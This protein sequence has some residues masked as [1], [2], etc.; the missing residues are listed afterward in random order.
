MNIIRIMALITLACCTSLHAANDSRF[1]RFALVIG[2][3]DGGAS[4]TQLRFSFSDAGSF[5]RVM[6]EIGG[7]GKDDAMLLYQPS[8]DLLLSAMTTMYTRV[9]AAGKVHRKTEFIFYYSGHS[10]ENGILLGGEKVFY[11]E[12]FP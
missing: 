10:D 5:S 9:Q 12:I 6:K 4:R 3:N 1:R 2:A 7:V 8:R 11:S